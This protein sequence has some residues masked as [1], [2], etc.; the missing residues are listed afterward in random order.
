M[1]AAVTDEAPA[2]DLGLAAVPVAAFAAWAFAP[3]VPLPALSLAV[4]VPVVAA[5]R[6][7][8]LEPLLFEVSLLALVVG[9]WA[10]SLASAVT[11]GLLAVISPVITSVIQDPSEFSVGVWLIGIAFP[12]VIGRAAARQMQL[13]TQLDATRRELAEQA[14]LEERSSTMRGPA[15]WTCGCGPAGTSPRSR[16]ASG[17]RSTGSPRKRWRMRPGTRRA[18]TVLAL[19]VA[20]GRACL[21]ADTAGPTVPAPRSEPDRP[22][23]GLVG[24]RERATALGGEF[25]AGPTTEGWRVS[26]RLPLEATDTVTAGDAHGR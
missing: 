20:D 8:Q 24:M 12:W 1:L 7:G 3:A 4:L 26:C 10:P 21:L 22:R 6:S 9:M 5:Q 16:R 18:R 23:F 17:S 19:E 15:V 2:A 14:L 11:L 13:T 25:A